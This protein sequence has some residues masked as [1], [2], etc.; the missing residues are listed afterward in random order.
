MAKKRKNRNNR[1]VTKALK[2]KRAA[3]G[4]I[5]VGGIGNYQN[6]TST[7]EQLAAQQEKLAELQK[8]INN[9][10]AAKAKADAQAAAKAKADAQARA[11]TRP[12]PRGDL[13]DRDP[14]A[15]QQ[16][17]IAEFLGM[18]LAEIQAMPL[19]EAKELYR[20][21]QK[22]I[23]SQ[24]FQEDYAAA[25]NNNTSNN[26]DSGI[27]I[28]EERTL[29]VAPYG[30][31]TQVWNGTT[32]V[33]KGSK[34]DP[35]RA[36]END[37]TGNMSLAELRQEAIV[38]P[39]GIAQN[40]LNLRG[41]GSGTQT[42][43]TQMPTAKL[44]VTGP[45]ESVDAQ[46]LTGDYKASLARD[47]IGN[48]INPNV[49]QYFQ[50]TVTGTAQGLRDPASLNVSRMPGV[51]GMAA[52][53]IP[54]ADFATQAAPTRLADPE[55]IRTTQDTVAAERDAAQEIAAEARA[56]TL[57]SDAQV[58]DVTFRSTAAVSPTVEAEAA[59]RAEITGTRADD[60]AA[61]Q[62]VDTFGFGSTRK[63]IID[64]LKA[65]TTNPAATSLT[66]NSNLSQQAAST[67]VTNPGALDVTQPA[68]V[69][70]VAEL[71][72]E[73]LVSAQMDKLLEDLEDDKVPTWARPA[74]D[75]VNSMMAQR[76][77]Q[78]STV[79]RDALFNSI[80]QSAFPIAQ[81]NAQ[82]LQTRATQNLSN[83][84]QAL[85]QENQIAAD[86]LSKN[87][88]FQ[89]QMELANLNNDQQMRLANLSSRNQ[90][91]SEQ[92]TADQQ[93]ELANLNARLQTN[94]LQG[95][96]AQQLGVAQLSVDQQRAIQN[97]SM[98]ANIDLTQFNA[99]QQ[100][101]LTNSKFMQSM[102]M[103]DF[104][105]EQQT[106]MQEATALA[107][108]DMAAVDQRT[109]IAAQQAQSFLQLDMAN[110]NN[111]QQAQILKSQQQQQQ[112]LSNQSFENARQQFNATSE[113]QLNQ[114]FTGLQSQTSMQ[115]AQQHNAM[116]QFNSNQG[117]KADQINRANILQLEQFNT[118]VQY[119]ADQWNA[120]NAQ[121]V[122]QSNIEW[123]RKA[124][125]VDTA[126][127]NQSNQINVQNAFNMQSSALAQI[128]QQLRDSATFAV[129]MSTNNQD[130]AAR[131]IENALANGD[132]MDENED[133]RLMAN[134]LYGIINTINGTSY[135]TY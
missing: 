38:D 49:G 101:E 95:K 114:F 48:P 99:E 67:I 119:Q 4:G 123:R 61:A 14:T 18:S 133:P 84:Q 72:E 112:R 17:T 124:N 126:A 90:T 82:A 65:S 96:I 127:E 116:R 108:L 71:P 13:P 59:T 9:E 120:A 22:E 115:N 117:L 5:G 46:Q 106:V 55:E 97:A 121:A 50:G 87:A 45:T 7:P 12:P 125:T 23:G 113:N 68:L 35:D 11:G 98:T 104:N 34:Q 129:Q 118:Q 64:S 63:Q 16:N 6:I 36:N 132:M 107:S 30:T 80:I 78:A 3:V 74:V 89:Q 41:Y 28:G 111:E 31:V 54:T 76:G 62:I 44:G 102:T 131:I 57:T 110:I 79:G 20:I 75:A 73:A 15:R 88:A 58:Q 19:T 86:F 81:A 56:R 134:D 29:N 91:A 24:Q 32:W 135:S 60:R 94:L 52:S 122:E 10:A 26:T 85:I 92:M 2:R 109:K 42:P 130:R 43:T 93:T 37:P 53:D 40:V 1:S 83:Q 70:A 33:Q 8:Q 51:V 77:L 39:G 25:Q 128:W 105:A 21:R 27:A 100:V 69:A 47:A 66:Q 103:A